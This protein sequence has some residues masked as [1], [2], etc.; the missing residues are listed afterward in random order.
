MVPAPKKFTQ[1]DVVVGGEFA[2]YLLWFSNGDDTTIEHKTVPSYPDK[3]VT[4]CS[5]QF[6][7]I[8]KL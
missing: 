8:R 1:G 2:Q 6:I 3:S 7:F 4:M 5:W